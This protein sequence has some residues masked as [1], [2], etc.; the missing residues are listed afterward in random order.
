MLRICF[1]L[2]VEDLLMLLVRSWT[3]KGAGRGAGP[4]F[5]EKPTRIADPGG[6][7]IRR[8]WA[9]SSEVLG[10]ELCRLPSSTSPGLL[11]WLHWLKASCTLP[12]T[13]GRREAVLARC[14]GAGGRRPARCGPG[15]GGDQ[16]SGRR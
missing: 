14:A 12:T 11:P 13:R 7:G 2:V 10:E 6:C 3:I 1:F 4:A 16:E 15:A 9:R 5:G 8:S